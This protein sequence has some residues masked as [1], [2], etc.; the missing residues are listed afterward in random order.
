MDNDSLVF[1]ES[2]DVAATHVMFGRQ[3]SDT[4]SR[5]RMNLVMDTWSYKESSRE[6]ERNE[7]QGTSQSEDLKDKVESVRGIKYNIVS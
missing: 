6:R 5:S 7:I 4:N 3:S 1:N 2:A